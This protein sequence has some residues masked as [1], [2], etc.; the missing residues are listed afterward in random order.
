[1]LGKIKIV[2]RITE[3]P[4]LMHC[5]AQQHYTIVVNREPPVLFYTGSPQH[6]QSVLQSYDQPATTQQ[7]FVLALSLS[8]MCVCMGLCVCAYVCVTT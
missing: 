2:K 5:V 8:S 4:N 6:Q 7:H 3:I 1:M